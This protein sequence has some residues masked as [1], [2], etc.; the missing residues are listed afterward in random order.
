MFS[1]DQ[2]ASYTWRQWIWY[3]PGSRLIE[4]G[5]EWFWGEMGRPRI[6]R[7]K[8]VLPDACLVMKFKHGTLNYIEN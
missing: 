4:T 8:T 5:A 3:T 7:P 2:W 1:V 6:Q